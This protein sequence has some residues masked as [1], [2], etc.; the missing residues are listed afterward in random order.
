MDRS[1]HLII[2][3]EQALRDILEMK[4]EGTEL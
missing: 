3:A 4:N 2:T 1:L